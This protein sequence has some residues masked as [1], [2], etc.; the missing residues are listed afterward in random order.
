METENVFA[1]M[2]WRGVMTALVTPPNSY[3]RLRSSPAQTS[4]SLV[5]RTP[6]TVSADYWTPKRMTNALP[7]PQAILPRA[8]GR[9]MPG[10]GRRFGK[11]NWGSWG[12]IG[13]AG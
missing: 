9:E 13:R 2:E 12:R 10:P 8:P 4:T 7:I 11:Y 5:N 3:W 6:V 1:P